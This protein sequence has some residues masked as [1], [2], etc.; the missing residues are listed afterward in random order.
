MLSTWIT[1]TT[2]AAYVAYTNAQSIDPNSV[3]IATRRE[4]TTTNLPTAGSANT[5]QRPGANHKRPNAR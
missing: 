5:Y 3:P 1:A 4:Y 2:L